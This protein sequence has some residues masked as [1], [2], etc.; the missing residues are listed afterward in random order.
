MAGTYNEKVEV[1]VSGTTGNRI[2]F[3]N[4]NNDVVIITGTGIPSLDAII[5]IFDQSFITIQGLQIKDNEQLDA[6]GIIVEGDCQNIEIRN[7]DISNINFSSDQNAPINSSTN[8]QPII[9]YGSNASNAIG[10][11]IIDGNIVH[12]SRTGFSEALAVN[13]NVDGF[14]VTN[15]TVHDITNIGIDL[16][17]HEDT[18]SS[19]DQARNGTVKGNTVYKCVSPYATAG[20]I[21]V[22][23]AKDL[24]IENNVVYQ[25]QWGIEVGCENLSKSASG[26]KVRN[27]LIYGNEDAGLAIGG[28]N[29]PSESGKV[30]NCIITN[31]TC[32][33]NDTNAG[34]V[35]GISGEVNLTYTENCT[36]ENNIFYATNSSD[37]ILYVDNVN[38]VN[39]AMDYNLYYIVGNAEFDF[40][41]T[42]YTSF[43]SYQ[44]GTGLDGNSIFNDPLFNDTTIPDLHLTSSSPGKDMGNPSFIA[45]LNETDIDGESRVQNTRVDV[46]ADEYN[47]LSSA[48]IFTT[49]S[50][51]TIYPN[52]FTDMV[53]LDG[54]FINFDIIVYDEAGTLVADYSNVTSPLTIDLTALGTGIYFVSLQHVSSSQLSV[55][56]IIKE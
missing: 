38:S 6:Q 1:N 50:D 39:L 24:V 40:E 13:G 31:N 52:P 49:S 42:T 14:E 55:Y 25:C 15:N 27:N 54:N 51:I 26:I 56:Q 18:A 43:T 48:H 19:N 53:V 30:V 34:G 46:G 7:N 20:G 37:L 21:Y 10:N 4:Y 45:D 16:I 9:I 28:Y 29:Y 41:N 32:Y 8:S 5:G 17:G 12:N 3:Q 44:S 22:D 2:T 11:L 35:G 23:G 36:I 47:I 33:N